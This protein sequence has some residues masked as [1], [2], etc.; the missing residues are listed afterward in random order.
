MAPHTL[1]IVHNC[2]Y[3]HLQCSVISVLRI[4]L[5]GNDDQKCYDDYKDEDDDTRS[6]SERLTLAACAP[7]RVNRRDG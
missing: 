2:T 6:V 1:H 7:L 4:L 3:A 5:D